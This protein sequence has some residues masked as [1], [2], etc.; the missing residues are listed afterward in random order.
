M[1][2]DEVD[3]IGEFRINYYLGQKEIQFLVLDFIPSETRK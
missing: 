1:L 2:Y 3:F